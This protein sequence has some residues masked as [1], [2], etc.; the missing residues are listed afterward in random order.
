MNLM[1]QRYGDCQGQ[2]WQNLAKDFFGGFQ[3][4]GEEGGAWI[5]KN[6]YTFEKATYT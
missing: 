4:G 6:N 1:K 2:T 5:P 3:G